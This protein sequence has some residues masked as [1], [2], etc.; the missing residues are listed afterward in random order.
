MVDFGVEQKESHVLIWNFYCRFLDQFA[1]S[2]HL[3]HTS[4]N[5]EGTVRA[6]LGAAQ[7][8]VIGGASVVFGVKAAL[9]DTNDRTM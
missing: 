7:R 1:Q 2:R 8:A 9:L 4:V 3:W 5:T 6:T